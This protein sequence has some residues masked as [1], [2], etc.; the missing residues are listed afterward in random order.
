MK[1]LSQI[2]N[3]NVNVM[4]L[5][6]LVATVGRLVP[7]VPNMTSLLALSLLAGSMLNKKSAALITLVSL[8]LSDGLLSYFMGYPWLGSWSLFTYS[9]FLLIALV[10]SSLNLSSKYSKLFLITLFSSFGY[11]VWTNLGVWWFSY[12]HSLQ[13]LSSCYLLALPFLRN[14]LVG[15]VAWMF[16]LFVALSKLLST[17]SQ[18][19]IK[20]Q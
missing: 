1:W 17:F 20:T 8:L 7:H 18:K 15:D 11:W 19:I 10:G 13:G 4:L 12:P 6:V 16:V 9:G 5:W 2:S 14:A 3:K